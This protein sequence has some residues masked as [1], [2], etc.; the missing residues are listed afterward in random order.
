MPSL[1]IDNI[2][3]TRESNTKNVKKISI[4]IPISIPK[5]NNNYNTTE[6]FCLNCSNFNPGKM[7]PPD[8]WKSRLEQRINQYYN[9]YSRNE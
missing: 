8:L 1:G 3:N 6:E 5:Q 2:N 9:S 4:S 7:S